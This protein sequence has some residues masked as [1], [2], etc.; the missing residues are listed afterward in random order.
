MSLSES[1]VFALRQLITNKG[2]TLLTMLG[3]F[4]GIGSVIM[5]L[6]LGEGF[7][8]MMSSV[9]EDIGMGAFYAYTKSGDSHNLITK[10]DIEL[11]NSM[12][13]MKIVMGGIGAGGIGYDKDHDEIS[14]YLYGSDPKYPEEIAKD[15]LLAGRFLTSDDDR[16]YA[17]AMVVPDYF[18]KVIFNKTDYKSII[19]E[20]VSIKVNGQEE[21][22]TIVGV[23]KTN[24]KMTETK[25]TLERRIAGQK[26]YVPVETLSF[27][28]EY[29]EGYSYI[30]GIA[31]S[32]YDAKESASKVR[33][34]LN[35]R[36]QQKDEYEVI[37]LAQQLD[38]INDMLDMIT[39][40]IGAVASI[41]L[42]VGGVG[43][44][45][46]MLVT[47]KERTREIGVR[48]AL[49]A[50]NRVIL[51]QFLIEAL[52]LT[53]IG[54]LIGML[55][56]YV[57]AMLIGAQFDIPAKLTTGMVLFS[58]GISIFIGLVFGVYPAYQAAQLEPIEALRYE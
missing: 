35:K 6:G 37:S 47:V 54:G 3:M 11:I 31:N 8:G 49:G 36:H 17:K 26:L 18:A 10:E 52:I 57:G 20:D 13:E 33:N 30:D 1:I 51:R 29:T 21:Q 15:E 43:I 9:G 40:F 45:N 39:L 22:F 38:M 48:K 19:G 46:I 24:I 7:K 23:Y 4:I 32:E 14:L 16:A 44:M 50:T 27:I 34:F 25:E 58:S 41:S 2:R 42:L 55:I 56:G 53:V 5:I 28:L 12:P